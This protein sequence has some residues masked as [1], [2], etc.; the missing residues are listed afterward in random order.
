MDFNYKVIT[1]FSSEFP[2]LTGVEHGIETRLALEDY[3]Y[4][5]M[6]V[7]GVWVYNPATDVSYIIPKQYITG[8]EI[9]RLSGSDTFSGEY[10]VSQVT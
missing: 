4:G 6:S 7:G 10:I 5:S 1:Y 2:A 3:I 8:E 9:H